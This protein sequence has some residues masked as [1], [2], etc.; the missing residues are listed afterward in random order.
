MNNRIPTPAH[1]TSAIQ[2]PYKGLARDR[3]HRPHT[4]CHSAT[5]DVVCNLFRVGSQRRI[6][7]E[8]RPFALDK[9]NAI[10]PTDMVYHHTPLFAANLFMC[11]LVECEYQ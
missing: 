1:Q 9:L 4:R 11:P 10:V 3:E 7:E 2:I 8:V 5:T 6:S